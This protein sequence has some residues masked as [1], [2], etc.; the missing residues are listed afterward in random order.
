MSTELVTIG[1]TA[2]E[3]SIID[4]IRELYHQWQEAKNSAEESERRA[5]SLAAEIGRLLL[6]VKTRLEHGEWLPWIDANLPFQRRMAQTYMQIAGAPEEKR[7]AVAHL[8]VRRQRDELAQPRQ[9]KPSSQDMRD[10]FATDASLD[11]AVV[12]AT[13]VEVVDGLVWS[14]SQ[15]KNDRDGAELLR[16]A[17]ALRDEAKDETTPAAAARKYRAA[18]VRANRAAAAFDTVAMEFK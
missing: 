10:V 17:Q 16:E 18:A 7:N 9:P 2:I 1:S 12:P 15:L 6:E 4:A 14:N 3:P 11:T 8:P 13:P 5:E